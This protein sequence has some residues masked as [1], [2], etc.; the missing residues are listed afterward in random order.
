MALNSVNGEAKYDL[1][2]SDQYLY[3][4]M[5]CCRRE[6]KRSDLFTVTVLIKISCS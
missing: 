1:T 2:M 3:G 6:Q 5:Y 4:L